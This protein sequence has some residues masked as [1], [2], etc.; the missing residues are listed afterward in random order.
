M[1]YIEYNEYK[2]KYDKAHKDFDNILGEKEMLF[3]RTQPKAT[4]YKKEVVS[5][6]VPSNT[7]DTYLVVKEEKQIDELL[8]EAKSILEDRQRLLKLKEQELRSSK[9]WNDIIYTYYFLENLTIRKI[10]NRIP[11]SKSEIH[12]KLEIIRKNI[13]WGQNGN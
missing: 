7:F 12:R 3:S 2:N 8:E 1:V 4:D 6:G 5:G 13:N 9:N 10:S 11:L